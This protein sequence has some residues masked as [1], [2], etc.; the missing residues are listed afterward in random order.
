MDALVRTKQTTL[1]FRPRKTASPDMT[2]SP[3]PQARKQGDKGVDPNG[4]VMKSFPKSPPVNQAIQSRESSSETTTTTSISSSTEQV[5]SQ[6]LANGPVLDI[7]RDLRDKWKIKQSASILN[8]VTLTHEIQPITDKV[9]I[10]RLEGTKVRKSKS[11]AGRKRKPRPGIVRSYERRKQ[12]GQCVDCKLYGTI[13]HDEEHADMVCTAC[14]RVQCQ[15][16]GGAEGNGELEYNDMQA[17]VTRRPRQPQ[18]TCY[19]NANHFRDT[20]MQAQGLENLKLP[21]RVLPAMHAYIRNRRMSLKDLEPSDTYCILR[22]LK[23]SHLYKHKVKLTYL[24]SGKEPFALNAQ[25]TEQLCYNFQ[26]IQE[27]FKKLSKERF[28]RKNLISYSY[29]LFKLSEIHQYDKICEVCYL[30]KTNSKLHLL[31][32]IWKEICEK[33]AWPFYPSPTFNNHY[34]G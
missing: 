31:D 13:V 6:H 25:Q 2:V 32:A 10:E 5:P 29:I 8:F 14:G 21:A 30:L 28:P 19:D 23:L 22:D 15:T 16:L 24:L 20:L 26:E 3:E 33:L 17:R 34:K 27:P 4:D 9:T 7:N 1:P 11:N 12:Q 18:V